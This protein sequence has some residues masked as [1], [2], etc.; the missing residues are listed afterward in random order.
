M[1]ASKQE[2][3]GAT[4]MARPLLE[5]ANRQRGAAQTA[6]YRQRALTRSIA[7]A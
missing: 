7:Q 4:T 3:A 5:V 1:K 6:F 2:K